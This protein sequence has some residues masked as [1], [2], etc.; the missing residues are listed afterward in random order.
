MSYDKDR[1]NQHE[2]EINKLHGRITG[3]YI[4]LL[5]VVLT[6]LGGL[7][8]FMLNHIAWKVAP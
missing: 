3:V 4:M 8:V 2:A 6:A 1:C 7:V 5:G